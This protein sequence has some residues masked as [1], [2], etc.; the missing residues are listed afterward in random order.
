MSDEITRDPAADRA[1]LFSQMAEQI[2]LNKDAKFGGA[3]VLM[4]PGDAEPVVQLM[5]GVDEPSIFWA[6][7]QT[8]ANM[9]VAALDSAQRAAGFGRR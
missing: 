9:G 6:S 3:F 8:L 2:L 4:P 5:L 7:L 1:A